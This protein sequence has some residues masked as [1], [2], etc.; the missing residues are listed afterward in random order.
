MRRRYE[1]VP[2]VG[3]KLER[4]RVVCRQCVD[5]GAVCQGVNAPASVQSS[6]ELHLA[7][8]R[9]GY[10][11]G[12]NVGVLEHELVFC[13]A[14]CCNLVVPAIIV[15]RGRLYRRAV[16]VSADEELPFG[17]RNGYRVLHAEVAH[18]GW[19]FVALYCGLR[20]VH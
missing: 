9:L 4:H 18:T 17:V 6:G 15:R 14:D 2:V 16:E 3:N 7:V 20:A 5:A 19:V 10:P 11:E 13:S 8:L 12:R 1:L